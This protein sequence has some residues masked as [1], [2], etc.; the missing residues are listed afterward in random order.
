MVLLL[1]AALTLL[2]PN[3]AFTTSSVPLESTTFPGPDVLAATTVL[4]PEPVAIVPEPEAMTWLLPVPNE[5][6]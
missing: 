2:F 6:T 1:P 4:C 5:R 3:K